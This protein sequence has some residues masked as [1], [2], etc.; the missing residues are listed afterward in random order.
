MRGSSPSRSCGCS[1]RTGGCSAC[2]TAPV[3]PS[4]WPAPRAAS[5]LGAP[6]APRPSSSRTTSCAAGDAARTRPAVCLVC[7]GGPVQE[8][9]RGRHPGAG[10]AGGAGRRA[11]H[12]AD[13]DLDAGGAAVARRG[14]H[15][16][17]AAADRPGRRRRLPRP[18][19][20]AARAPLPGRR[21]GAGAGRPGRPRGRGV[22]AGLGPGRRSPA[23][24][25]PLAGPRGR[26]GRR[27]RGRHRRG[28]SRAGA[29]RAPSLPAVQRHGG[30]LR[31]GRARLRRLPSASRPGSRS[32]QAA[33]GRWWVRA[34]D[35]VGLCDA[36]ARGHPAT[37]VACGSRSTRC[38]SDRYRPGAGSQSSKRLPSGSTPHAN[39]P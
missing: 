33:E 22:G 38:G 31:R 8:R 14:R 12:R 11:R 36:L 3:G 37:R 20:G 30:D 15:R 19:P 6:S 23:P 2:S 9:P 24:P 27:A 39:R 16:G 10:G 32:W 1:A 26:A 13:G 7:G 35:H 29:A 21:A 4:C 28:R 34:A 5:W 18:R 17:G 25:D